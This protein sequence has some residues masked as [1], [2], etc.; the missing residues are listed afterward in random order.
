MD[1]KTKLYR[2]KE[3][4]SQVSVFYANFFRIKG[5]GDNKVIAA[6]LSE[7]ATLTKPSQKI[8]RHNADR[9]SFSVADISERK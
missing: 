4:A 6:L 1:T 3:L 8:Y 9:K 7:N 2:K 5:I